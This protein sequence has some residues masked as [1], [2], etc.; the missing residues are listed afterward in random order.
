M[1]T[2]D[3]AE[4]SAAGRW[5]W[6]DLRLTPVA[7][8]VWAVSACAPLF[9]PP[10]LA[11]GAATAIGMAAAVARR[12]N[13][14]T[15]AVALAVLAGLAVGTAA[16]AVRGIERE[17]SPLRSVTEAGRTVVLVLEL[18]ADPHVLS[19]S[20]GRRVIADATVTGLTDGPVTHRLDATVLLFAAADGWRDVLPGQPVRVRA[21]VSAAQP[22]DD[23]VAVVSARGPPTRL[24]SPGVLQRAA[25]ALREGLVTSAGRVLAPRP[26][27][28]LPGLIVGDTR[29]MDPVLDEDF[30]RAGLAHLTAV[31]GA[32]VSSA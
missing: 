31:S 4:G 5:H 32:N 3:S 17:A 14:R 20:A 9:T 25:G 10:Q 26:A 18:D 27:G 12:S 6:V 30:E 16:A 15:A 22:G 21:A 11:L 23:V 24:G 7:A 13:G 19:G 8:A 28:L 2:V 29:S 1:S